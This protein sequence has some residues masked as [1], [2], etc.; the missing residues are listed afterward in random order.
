MDWLFSGVFCFGY[1]VFSKQML[2]FTKT[3]SCKL[4]NKAVFSL[5]AF[6]TRV[7]QFIYEVNKQTSPS[8]PQLNGI[9][10]YFDPWKTLIKKF[11]IQRN[12]LLCI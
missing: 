11:N 6:D 12:V 3:R 1:I 8:T 7:S 2:I 9:V 5:T 4:F 10:Y